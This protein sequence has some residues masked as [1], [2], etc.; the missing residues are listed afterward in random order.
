[1]QFEKNIHITQTTTEVT[2]G[3]NTFNST[4]NSSSY[5]VL[6]LYHGR[7]GS[8]GYE[9]YLHMKTSIN[10]RD[11]RSRTIIV[12]PSAVRGLCSDLCPAGLSGVL[13]IG[14]GGAKPPKPGSHG[15]SCASGSSAIAKLAV[16]RRER[17]GRV[18]KL[19]NGFEYSAS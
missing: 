7:A 10:I 1:M 2:R 9:Q 17:G 16:F 14:S 6:D 5:L 13:L 15:A 3:E 11:S 18:R 4:T 19:R 12:C 8:R